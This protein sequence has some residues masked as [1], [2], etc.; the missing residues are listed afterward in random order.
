VILDI[1]LPQMDGM[2][3]LERWR[4][5]GKQDAGADP[6][7][8][9]PLERQG[10]GIDAGADDYVAKPFHIEEVLARCAR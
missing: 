4:R 7:R 6:H 9:R 1:G 5:D 8:A 3:V 10:A 2:S